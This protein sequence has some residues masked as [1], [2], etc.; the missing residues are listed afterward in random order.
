MMRGGQWLRR[1]RASPH[2]EENAA[3]PNHATRVVFAA[4]K[5]VLYSLEEC[6]VSKSERA[7][8]AQITQAPPH[9]NTPLAK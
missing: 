8:N 3:A 7:L 5:R 1:A 9:V 4:A 6:I 2:A